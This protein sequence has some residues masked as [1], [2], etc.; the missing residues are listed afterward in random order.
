MIPL[1]IAVIIIVLAIVFF[2]L[3]SIGGWVI[4]TYNLLQNGSQNIKN[5]WS[6]V[7]TEYQRRADV[8]YN[9]TQTVKSYAKFEKE[10]MISVI[11]ARSGNFGTNIQEQM[12]TVK[13]L[14]SSFASVLSKL[15][16]VV[17]KYPKLLAIEE[18]KELSREVR[19]TE[20][21]IN[22]ARTDF[23]GTVREFNSVVLTFP[24]KIIAKK[25]GFVEHEYY[26]NQPESEK[27]Y[28]INFD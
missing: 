6:N 7:L 2:L 5:Q 25:Y 4:G 21:R 20:D 28:K 12:K 11:Q 10:T 14:D 16:V 23:N 27:N 15:A 26:V 9:L 1:I 18:Y 13:K 17:E 22:I 3:L 8:L 19:N 24:N